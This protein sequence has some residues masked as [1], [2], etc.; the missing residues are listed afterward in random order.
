MVDGLEWVLN[1]CIDPTVDFIQRKAI[2]G[3]WNFIEDG[4]TQIETAW[5]GARAQINNLKDVVKTVT[6]EKCLEN[7]NIS[8]RRLSIDYNPMTTAINDCTRNASAL[9]RDPIN[10]FTRVHFIA[11]PLI[12]RMS[13]DLTFCANGNRQED[14]ITKY[15]LRY[16]EKT[17][18]VC[19]TM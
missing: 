4:D 1:D 8:N 3:F 9:Y 2:L 19:Q 14:C 11:L 15:L 5:T 18:K 10:N 7:E 13:T 12:N 6:D 16:C 17:C